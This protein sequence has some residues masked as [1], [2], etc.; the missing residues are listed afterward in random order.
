MFVQDI[1]ISVNQFSWTPFPTSWVTLNPAA[2]PETLMTV[3]KSICPPSSFVTCTFSPIPNVGPCL[4][5][6]PPINSEDPSLSLI[7]FP[8]PAP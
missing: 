4:V 1:P 7:A 3:L 5:I 8:I 6:P 2:T